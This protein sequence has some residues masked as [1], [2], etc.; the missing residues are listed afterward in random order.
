MA[1]KI[2][3]PAHDRRYER[4]RWQILFIA[5]LAYVGFY[6]TRKSFSV[7]KIELAKPE[8]LGWD[9][10]QMA[11]VDGA[12]LT[13]YALGSFFWGPLGDR[14][15][16]R[17]VVSLGL[18]TSVLVALLMGA[19][20]SVALMSLLF[21]IQ[22][23]CQSSGWAP[24]AKN[25]GE[26]FSMRERGRI[27]GIWCTS[28]PAGGFVAGWIAAAAA[29]WWGWR[30][31]IWAP[32]G[33]LLLIALLFRLLQRDRPEDVGLPPIEKYHGER[34]AVVVEGESAEEEPEGS[35][36]V[37]GEVLTNRMVWLLAGTYLLIKPT[38]YLIM[39]WAPT[40]VHERLG[41]ELLESSI[42]GSL[43]D[44]AGLASPF[45]GG[46]LSDKL[47]RAKRMPLTV[48]ALFGC[49]ALW[50]GFGYLPATRLALGLGLF[51]IGFLIYIPETLL[52]ASAAIDFGTKK[53][54]STASGFING[55]GSVGA[56]IGITVPG[57]IGKTIEPGADQWQPI[58]IG[59]ALGLALAAL[60]L[61]PQWNRLPAQ[62]RQANLLKNEAVI[63]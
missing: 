47:F 15:G 51:G 5:W 30:Y 4:W 26:F 19:S 44:L 14:F 27:L 59:L 37:I 34:E 2:D 16:A 53:G 41:T 46:W 10:T 20:S 33:C 49:A 63:Q 50:F 40:Y 21:G 55:C 29:G 28:M 36:K 3:P 56:L 23:L 13:V 7:T 38:R 62:S 8:V 24:L 22:G 6:L 45:L 58:F 25:L 31:S 52:S 57:W 61:V 32:A 12:F 48:I 60:L 39:G 43:P 17:R 35:W 11:W 9:K 18:F 54:A 1:T 42:V